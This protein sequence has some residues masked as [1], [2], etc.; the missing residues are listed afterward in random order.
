MPHSNYSKINLISHLRLALENTIISISMIHIYY[1]QL[2][3]NYHAFLNQWAGPDIGAEARP[4]SRTHPVAPHF[5][6]LWEHEA[7]KD[8]RT[9]PLCPT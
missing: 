5:N 1:L 6:C 2:R 4:V 9:L 7:A 3:Q 8:Q